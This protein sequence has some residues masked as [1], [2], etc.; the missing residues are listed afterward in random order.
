MKKSKLIL[1]GAGPG[2]A[3]LI[4]LRGVNAIAQADVILYDALVDV[5]L[6][7]YAS[8]SAIKIF[9]GKTVGAHYASQTEINA[10]IVEHALQNKVVVRLKGGDPGIFGR[11]VEEITT[12]YHHDIDVEVVPGVSSVTGIPA[13]QQIPLTQRGSSESIWITTGTTSRCELSADIELA[14]Q[15]SATVLIVMGMSRLQ[16]IVNIFRNYRADNHPI[17]LIHKGSTIEEKCIIGTLGNIM[18]LYATNPLNSPSLI[19]IGAKKLSK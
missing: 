6:L 11:M 9:V 8:T 4:T 17:A 12:A 18:N 7:D 13:L 10:L 16:E 3:D 5:S 15:S 19:L 14:A 2:A 1:V